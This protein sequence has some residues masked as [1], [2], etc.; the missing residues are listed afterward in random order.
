MVNRWC[1]AISWPWSQVSDRASWAGRVLDRGGERVGDRVG[2]VV[3][4]GQRDE[5][6]EPGGAFDQGG[7]RAHALAEDQVA[8]PVTG[9]RPVLG[10]G[11]PFGDVQDVRPATAAV[12]Q[13]DALGAAEHPA[14]AQVARSAPCAA[15][16]GTARTG[17]G[18]CSRATPASPGR[19]GRS[20][21]SQPAIC[22]GDH[23]RR[24][25]SA[26][27]P[28]STGFV[29]QLARLGPRRPRPRLPVRARGPVP[30]PATVGGDLTADRRRRPPQPGR[31]RPHRQPRRQAT[32]DL[33]ALRQASAGPPP[34]AAAPAGSRHSAPDRP[35]PCSVRQ[36]QLPRGRLRRLPRP[37]PD[38]HLVD[39]LRRQ[40]LDNRLRATTTSSTSRKC[41]A[42]PLRAPACPR[43]IRPDRAS[44]AGP[45]R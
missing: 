33:L 2:L 5:H 11:R 15:R 32:R 1:W 21:F 13:P 12:G 29:G 22:C 37:Q 36:P 30:P 43:T 4:V 17:C 45:P 8:F 35:A 14:G 16:R 23:R 19:R 34:A 42:D 9:H 18:R 26:T 27:M 40:P 24:S 10:L 6:Q 3:A 41:C 20:A 25:F 44:V 39:L 38:P 7:D 31:D 28:A